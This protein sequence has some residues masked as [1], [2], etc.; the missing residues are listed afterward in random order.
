M[1]ASVSANDVSGDPRRTV[2]VSATPGA[3]G[4]WK[5]PW[6][7]SGAT[8]LKLAF[9]R[10]SSTTS[11]KSW[12]RW[13]WL[14]AKT[15]SHAAALRGAHAVRCHLDSAALRT[16]TK[17]RRSLPASAVLRPLTLAT[18]TVTSRVGELFL[19]PFIPFSTIFTVL[20]ECRLRQGEP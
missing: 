3:S 7:S 5:R 20:L 1:S 2:H 9:F 4:S 17:T 10:P 14:T 8:A 19:C 13:T 12:P 6:A 11:T 18:T 16:L 15:S